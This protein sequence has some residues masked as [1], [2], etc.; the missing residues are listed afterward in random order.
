[1]YSFDSENGCDTM[2]IHFSGTA[3]AEILE[4]LKLHAGVFTVDPTKNI[5]CFKEL[6]QEYQVKSYIHQSAENVL[7]IYL[8]TI[9]S[10]ILTI[11][12]RQ[13]I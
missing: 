2:W 12:E 6:I 4:G 13:Q 9:I 11:T 8:L 10:E 3:A 1:M 5:F 7:L